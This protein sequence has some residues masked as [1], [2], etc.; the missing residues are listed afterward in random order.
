MPEQA[1]AIRQEAFM[2]RLRRFLSGDVIVSE[3]GWPPI[4]DEDFKEFQGLVYDLMDLR[5]GRDPDNDRVID[6]HMVNRRQ[7]RLIS[8]FEPYSPSILDDDVTDE[9]R[10]AYVESLLRIQSMLTGIASDRGRLAEA[11]L[12]RQRQIVAARKKL[13]D[14]LHAIRLRLENHDD[15]KEVARD[16]N[17]IALGSGAD[18]EELFLRYRR[19]Y[20]EIFADAEAAAI[21]AIR[22]AELANDDHVLIAKA[23]SLVEEGLRT[24]GNIA[25]GNAAGTFNQGVRRRRA[26]VKAAGGK[27]TE[28]EIWSRD[29]TQEFRHPK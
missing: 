8:V 15:F 28:T 1:Q 17:A 24:Y 12:Y 4:T 26:A 23:R 27:P 6:L 7:G 19:N 11:T 20:A 14:D 10:L 2:E 13:E 16:I 22:V 5:F 9:E 3:G 18:L 29:F 25:F 21:E